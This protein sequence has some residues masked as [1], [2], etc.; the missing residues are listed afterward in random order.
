[1][2][3]LILSV[4]LVCVSVIGISA[5]STTREVI[6]PNGLGVTI[7]T[8]YT[9]Q[10]SDDQAITFTSFAGDGVVNGRV[11]AEDAARDAF[12]TDATDAEKLLRA[13]RDATFAQFDSDN[14]IRQTLANGEALILPTER[15]SGRGWSSRST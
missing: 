12:N 10:I 8:S 4:L 13:Y 5:Q 2:K 6:A 14:L 7:P 9:A 11:I 3:R 15:F 1:M